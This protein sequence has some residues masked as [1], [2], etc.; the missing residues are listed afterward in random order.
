L[1]ADSLAEKVVE[2][3]VGRGLND[4][5]VYLKSGRSRRFE[6]GPQGR[7]ASSSQEEGWAVRAGTDRASLFVTGTGRPKPDGPWPEPDGQPLRLPPGAT[8]PP[9]TPPSDLGA[10]LSGEIE[11]IRLLEAIEKGVSGELA[12]ARLLRGQLVE[13]S[14]QTSVLSTRGIEAS[15]RSRAASL[16]VEM[17]GPW[18]GSETV[19]VAMA[20]RE[21][22]SFHSPTIAR[23]IVDRLLLQREGKSPERD[24]GEFLLA[25]ALGVRLLVALLPLVIGGG[26]AD[27]AGALRD[28][29][30]RIGSRLLT[31]K[32]DGRYRGGVLEAPIDGEGSPTRETVVIAEGRIRQPLI[33]WK[34]A[35][36]K[37]REASGCVRRPSWRDLPRVGPSHLFLAPSPEVKVASLLTGVARGYYLIETRGSGQFDLERDRFRLPVCGFTLRQGQPAVPLAGAWLTGS[38]SAWLRGIQ[39]V[40][41][42]LE[43]EPWSGMIGSP[44][45][46]VTGLEL[47]RNPN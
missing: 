14:S 22:R 2:A 44:T 20:R 47:R 3:L 12:G 6:L 28:R 30:G 35:K 39:G 32:D 33:S 42:D 9:W 11:A 27:L 21:L 1:S 7:I 34:E 38:I 45:T 29:Q 31:I 26:S 41:R 23:R 5:E 24:R 25:P 10:P 16:F 4:V 8:A 37:A 43:F 46:L 40:A 36:G 17:A 19:G 13:G 15:Y 18:P